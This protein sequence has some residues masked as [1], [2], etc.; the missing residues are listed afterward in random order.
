MKALSDGEPGQERIRSKYPFRYDDPNPASLLAFLVEGFRLATDTLTPSPWAPAIEID[1]AYPTAVR[2]MLADVNSFREAMNGAFRTRTEEM[3]AAAGV[4]VAACQ[5][6]V[7]ELVRGWRCEQLA[8]ELLV[9]DSVIPQSAIFV[10]AARV[11]AAVGILLRAELGAIKDTPLYDETANLLNA[12]IPR[13][14]TGLKGRHMRAGANRWRSDLVAAVQG[15]RRGCISAD[16]FMKLELQ[17]IT[18]IV[19]GL[20]VL[21]HQAPAVERFKRA[22]RGAALARAIDEQ[23]CISYRIGKADGQPLS[24]RKLYDCRR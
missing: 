14:E 13:H 22:G 16:D 17:Y 18:S 23:D 11:I 2:N 21:W 19:R 10:P 24:L 6:L 1:P 15:R 7:D 12:G 3:V 5:P 9:R 8:S 20:L 4:K